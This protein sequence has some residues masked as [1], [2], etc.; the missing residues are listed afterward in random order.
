MLDKHQIDQ[1]PKTTLAYWKFFDHKDYYGSDWAEKY[2]GQFEQIKEVYASSFL[3]KAMLLMVQ[4]RKGFLSI[5]QE[6]QE[7][8]KLMKKHAKTMVASVD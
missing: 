2:I 4:T 7:S 3:F 8:K 6:V 5:I 1:I